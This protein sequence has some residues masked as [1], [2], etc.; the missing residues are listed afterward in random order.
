MVM[1]VRGQS[2][3]MRLIGH[4]TLNGFGNGGE[5]ISLKKLPDG[6]RILFVAHEGPPKDFTVLDVTDPSAPK[7][8]TQVNLPHNRVRSNSLAL[9]DD[10]LLVVYQAGL[11]PSPSNFN[12]EHAGMAVWDIRDVEHPR[13]ISFFKTSGDHSRGAHYVWCVDG[14]YAH[15][16][17]GMP[18]SVPTHPNDDQ[19]Y[20][21]VDLADPARPREAGR[22]WLPGTQEGDAVSPPLR[23]HQ[24][25]VGF[26]AHNTN[27]YPERPD[28][29]YVGYID[30]GV[31][32]LDISDMSHPKMIS[33][34][35]YHPPFPGFTH[36]AL[37]LFNRNLLIATDECVRHDFEDWP[38]RIWVLD[39]REETNPVIISSFPAP[40]KDQFLFKGV[41]LGA[42][43]IHENEP[44]ST[45]WVS[46]DVIIGTFFSGGVIAYD[47]S[48]PFRPEE[49]AYYV[50]PA[51][52]GSASIMIND[53]Y[54]DERGLVYALDRIRGGLYILEMNI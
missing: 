39:G 29:A 40:P 26:R 36:T 34:V 1:G 21:I 47:I 2:K 54:V 28:R 46:E 32:I 50:P 25:D 15:L 35:D 18:D 24:F 33:R 8:I 43:N 13:R 30:G 31:I 10:L 48:D 12:M 27:V 38:K 45:S 17:T 6:R 9:A 37:P 5:G 3:N 44:L 7:V 51:P 19:F 49:V 53:L 4:N 42:H 22:W 41:R 23:H 52:E 11:D 14:R 16:S 20:V